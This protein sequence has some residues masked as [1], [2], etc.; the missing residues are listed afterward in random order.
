MQASKGKENPGRVASKKQQGVWYQ[1]AGWINVWGS[2]MWQVTK[3]ACLLPQY[4]PGAIAGGPENCSQEKC[5]RIQVAWASVWHSAKSFPCLVWGVFLRCGLALA[6]SL[7][8]Q[9]G[10]WSL[11]TFCG[12]HSDFSGRNPSLLQQNLNIYNRLDFCYC[13]MLS[14]VAN[15]AHCCL[16]TSGSSEQQ[17]PPWQSF[18]ILRRLQGSKWIQTNLIVK[19]CQCLQ[20]KIFRWP[21]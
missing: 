14:N 4:T 1:T 10:K 20:K 19:P 15:R 5:I 16:A 8:S 7:F 11:E 2:T 6:I 3:S 17:L 9:K 21:S 13:Y 12:R 18:T